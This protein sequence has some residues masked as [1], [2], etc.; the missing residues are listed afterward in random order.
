MD[1]LAGYQCCQREIALERDRESERER[2]RE[3]ERQGE[4][5]C[6]TESYNEAMMQIIWW[7][8]LSTTFMFNG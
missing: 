3:R 1:V 4:A 5:K 7:G 2:D 6:C 8:T